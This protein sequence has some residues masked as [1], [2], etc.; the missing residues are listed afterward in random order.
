MP[1]EKGIPKPEASSTFLQ[2]LKNMLR[3]GD[4]AGV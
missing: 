2:E 1:A 4:L 3:V